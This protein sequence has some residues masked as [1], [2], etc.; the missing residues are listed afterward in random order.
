MKA[1]PQEYNQP[2]TFDFDL[3]SLD[4]PGRRSVDLLPVV[5]IGG[6]AHAAALDRSCA[7]NRIKTAVAD[8]SASVVKGM[9]F[10]VIATD[11]Q[12]A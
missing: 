8:V 5:G 10:S 1:L 7:G 12:H 11:Y 9:K 6:L 4:K 2:F 3:E